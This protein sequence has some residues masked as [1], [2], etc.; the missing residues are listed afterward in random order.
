MSLVKERVRWEKL[1]EH[2]RY[3]WIEQNMEHNVRLLFSDQVNTAVAIVKKAM[4]NN[5]IECFSIAER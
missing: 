3:D 4:L 5:Q 2:K 1:L